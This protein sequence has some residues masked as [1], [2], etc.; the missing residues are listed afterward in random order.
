M[1]D[2]SVGEGRPLRSGWVCQSP[3]KC[4]PKVC[5]ST[6]SRCSSVRNVGVSRSPVGPARPSRLDNGDLVVRKGREELPPSLAMEESPL[7]MTPEVREHFR[8][9][10][11]FL[12]GR[13]DQIERHVE[14][15]IGHCGSRT[16]TLRATRSP[17]P[18]SPNLSA[19]VLSH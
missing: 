7:L 8:S 12:S 11:K 19:K 13:S 2:K 3:T 15:H 14:E 9:E 5:R 4:S 18:G 1:L 16:Q 17:G 6:I 10:K